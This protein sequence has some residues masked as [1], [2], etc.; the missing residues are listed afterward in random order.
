MCREA[1]PIDG[2]TLFFGRALRDIPK[3]LTLQDRNPYSPTYGCFDRNYWNYKILDFPS[4]MAQEFVLPLALAWATP[5][6][7][8]LFA[9]KEVVREW[10]RAGIAYAA[11]SAHSDGSCDDYFPFEKAA[12]AAAFSFYAVLRALDFTQ[13]DYRPFEAFLVRRATWLHAHQESGRLSNHE[14]L[15]ANGL[16]RLARLTGEPAFDRYARRRLDRVLTWQSE[17]GWFYEYQGCDP[18]YLTITLAMLSEMDEMDPALGLRPSIERVISFLARI[19]PPDGWFGGEW[20]SRNTHNYFPHGF[21]VCGRWLPEALAVNSRT[22]HAL[23]APPE[24]ADDHLVGHHCWSYLLAARLWNSDRPVPTV[25]E[26]GRDIFAEAGLVIERRSGRTLLT[27]SK[28]GGAFRLYTGDLL[29]HAD[30]GVAL[31]ISGGIPTGTAVC[32]LWAEDNAVLLEDDGVTVS[33]RMQ[34]AKSTPMTPVKMVVLR[35]FMLACGRFF[36]NLVR[37]LLQRLL[38]TGN[39][40][41]PFRFRRRLSWME[42]Q[43]AVEDE[44]SG[45]NWKRVSSAGIGAAQ[46]SLHSVTSRLYHPSQLAPW[47]DLTAELDRVTNGLLRVTRLL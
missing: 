24:Y 15:I 10:V 2:R 21:E 41:A 27:A 39:D 17:E 43:L 5:G 12:G 29:T 13:L 14:A 9:A 40:P 16:M 25:P 3:I 26:D 34:W 6:P 38:I 37:R 18:G 28:K 11:R 45:N 47:I 33:G 22:A 42:G 35:V 7:D 8:N 20:T 30:T 46:T 32:H 4:G 36:S 44:V 19:Q 23:L 1:H 31:K